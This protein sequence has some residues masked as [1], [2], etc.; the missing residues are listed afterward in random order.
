MD[1]ELFGNGTGQE[2]PQERSVQA[3]VPKVDDKPVCHSLGDTLLI[4]AERKRK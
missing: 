2:A 1:D 3:F 4:R